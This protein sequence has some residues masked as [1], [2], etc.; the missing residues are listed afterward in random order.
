M[1]KLTVTMTAS[2]Y[3]Y[4]DKY[5]FGDGELDLA[6]WENINEACEIIK[7]ELDKEFPNYVFN[8]EQA[9]SSSLHNNCRIT[10]LFKHETE[11]DYKQLD[12]EA[13]CTDDCIVDICVD[14]C[15]IDT[16]TE[17]R[18]WNVFKKAEKRFV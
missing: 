1:K 6:G 2:I 16:F 15:Y 10:I 3:E 11:T 8:V 13:D 17:K 18:V 5:G 9:F 4:F 7:D 14:E 12:I